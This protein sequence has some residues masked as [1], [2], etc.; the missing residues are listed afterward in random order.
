MA[1]HSFGTVDLLKILDSRK[2]A[3]RFDWY[4]VINDP[5][6]QQASKPDAYGLW[7]DTQKVIYL[8]M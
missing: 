5:D 2:R 4:G 1:T 3:E 6:M 8:K 7:L